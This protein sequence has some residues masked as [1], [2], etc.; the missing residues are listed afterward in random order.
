[1]CATMIYLDNA[2]STRPAPEVLEAISRAA[3]ELFANPS[4]AHGMGAAAARA[5]ERARAQLAEAL[6]AAASGEVLFTSGGSEAD[7]LGVLGAAK[8]RRGRHIVVSALEHPAVL[9]QADLL[10]GQ[11][12]AVTKVRPAPPRS[13]VVAAADVM[14]AVRPDT[15]VVAVMLV[16]N[17]LGTVQPVAEIARGL[18][19]TGL[20]A[21]LHVDA[22][23]A[24]G[25]VPIHGG[26][27]GA[28]SIAVSGH[29]VHGPKGAGALWLR[30]GARIAPLWDGG[31]QERG[32]R[33]GTE[34]V[35]GCVGLGEAA[36]LITR[37]LRGG[38]AERVRALRDELEARL[39]GALPAARPTAIALRPD[40]TAGDDTRPAA[41]RA[42]HIASI[43][44]PGLPA[45]P[46]LHALEARG[47]Y[48]SAGS[49]CASKAGG[50][51]PTVKAVGIPDGTAV[52]RFSLSR[53]T[54]AS[55]VAG[56]TAA[57][58]A[59]V[60]EIGGDGSESRWFRNSGKPY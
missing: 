39:F 40:T 7:A 4:S 8:A 5:V 52:L 2:A 44:L 36:E 58:C 24:F 10:A 1:M 25:L 57:L 49:A 19:A 56:A 51:S 27:L 53:E 29:K 11:G 9:L 60:E 34:N 43:A 42:P 20:R 41:A 48:A 13:G 22:V 14:A 26:A 28:D 50:A 32:L 12:Y 38:A 31:R 3:V 46:L 59:A 33:S 18:R 6:G 16:N 35:P 55:E 15:A 21:H 17:E 37:A 54:T 47:V 45:E 30:P 23:Q